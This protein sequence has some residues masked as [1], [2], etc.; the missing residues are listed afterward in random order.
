MEKISQKS[1]HFYFSTP[2]KPSVYAVFFE[3]QSC[4]NRETY[5]W[6]NKNS[7]NQSKIIPLDL[8]I[9]LPNPDFK[10]YFDDPLNG[11]IGRDDGIVKIVQ[12]TS[13]LPQKY[14]NEV[15]ILQ[16]FLKIG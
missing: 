6:K 3:W 13:P 1:S 4:G 16:G 11:T 12:K 15:L 14:N 5:G 10:P 9:Q 2:L 7:K 8:K